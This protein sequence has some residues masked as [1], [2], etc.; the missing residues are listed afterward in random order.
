MGY[1]FI[2]RTNPMGYFTNEKRK[3]TENRGPHSTLD[4]KKIAKKF[5]ETEKTQKSLQTLID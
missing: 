2:F 1:F 5:K 4:K 3:S